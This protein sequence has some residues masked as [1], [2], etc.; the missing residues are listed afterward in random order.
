MDGMEWHAVAWPGQART[1]AKR[2]GCGAGGQLLR[3]HGAW[4]GLLSP[5]LSSPV[6]K[7]I[8]LRSYH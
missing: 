1:G 6:V 7:L 8:L 3:F 4:M 5:P 2:R